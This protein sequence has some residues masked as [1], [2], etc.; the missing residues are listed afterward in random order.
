MEIAEQYPNGAIR[1]LS[2]GMHTAEEKVDTEVGNQH[3]QECGGAVPVEC[4][5]GGKKPQGTGVQRGRI[6]DNRN[7]GPHLLW[8]PSAGYSSSLPTSARDEDASCASG[9]EPRPAHIPITPLRASS[10]RRE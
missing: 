9:E 6:H 10:P 3:T 4:P 1:P 8:I 5:G 2:V 7:Q